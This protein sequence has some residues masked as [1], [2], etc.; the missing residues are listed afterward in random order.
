M[1][2]INLLMTF[3]YELF[4][5]EKSGSVQKCLI[6]PT[7]YI[8]DIL[9]KFKIQGIFF[10]DTTYLLELEKIKDNY[11]PVARD[12]EKIITQLNHLV[13]EGHLVYPHVHPH[14]LDAKYNPITNEWSLIN[15]RYYR[16]ESL[17]KEDLET[18][19]EKSFKIL[20]SNISGVNNENYN[21]G[22]RAGGWCIQPFS[23]FRDSF[24]KYGII[25][26]FSVLTGHK[27]MNR[28]IQFDFQQLHPYSKPYR[29][30]Y[31]VTNNDDKGRFKQFPISSIN[32]LRQNENTLIKRI[33]WRLGISRGIGDGV[34]ANFGESDKEYYQNNPLEMVAIELMDKGKC[35]EYYKLT[36]KTGY[37]HFISHPKM[38]SKFHLY[39]LKRFLKKINNEAIINSDWNKIQIN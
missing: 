39:Y 8:H 7:N 34:G 19:F 30:E 38:I 36:F 28:A 35:E 15:L 33:L 32:K 3:D 9:S 18:I 1:K 10:V 37:I 22:Y 11:P 27:I 16:A 5:G 12:F 2:E 21:W 4:L 24:I 23:V 29:F 26:E 31:D 25:S 6:E 13:S 20:K 14:W 17:P